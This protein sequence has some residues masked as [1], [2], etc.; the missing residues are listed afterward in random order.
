MQLA[1]VTADGQ[2]RHLR[3]PARVEVAFER[4]WKGGI[5][6]LLMNEQRAEHLYWIAH[7]LLMLD[8]VICKPFGDDFL[9][10][11]TSVEIEDDHPNG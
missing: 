5:Y 11:L 2:E 10:T 3:V 9:D 1:I 6:K 4:Y 7:Q 8:G